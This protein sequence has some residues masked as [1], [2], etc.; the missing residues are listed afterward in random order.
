MKSAL[1][2]DIITKF[3][4]GFRD[5]IEGGI[6]ES[7]ELLGGSRIYHIFYH[8][9]AGIL[10][11]M[12]PFDDLMDQDI[13]I[14]IRNATGTRTPLFVPEIAFEVLVQR[15]ISRLEHPSLECVRLVFI[16]LQKIFSHLEYTELDIY[17]N[18]RER[19]SII[20][21]DL[22]Q[23]QLGPCE[24]MINNL[25]NIENAYININHDDFVG[26]DSIKKV[27]DVPDKTDSSKNIQ[28]LSG[29][30]VCLLNNN[31]FN[32]THTKKLA[33]CIRL[34]ENGRKDVNFEVN[35]ISMY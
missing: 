35:L 25:L 21:N 15:Q 5:C 9:F 23:K 24:T 2:L 6:S 30:P 32:N 13:I 8:T 20:V 1:L 14:A 11:E 31:L 17:E 19:V 12:K 10:N 29:S 4:D 27:L 26:L 3:S 22:L 16:E 34:S 33:S 18:L 28:S 7:Q